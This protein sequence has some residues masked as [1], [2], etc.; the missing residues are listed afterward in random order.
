MK[1]K[2]KFRIFVI[3]VVIGFLAGDIFPLGE[4]NFYD[5]MKKNAVFVDKGAEK[6]FDELIAKS[7][8]LQSK[9]GNED[10]YP[11]QAVEMVAEDMA[12][13]LKPYSKAKKGINY[14]HDV[15]SNWKDLAKSNIRYGIDLA[16]GVEFL[17]YISEDK[18]ITSKKTSDIDVEG[19]FDRYRDI[20]I[21][22]LRNRLE[23]KGIFETE[24]SPSG[25]RYISLKAPIVSKDEKDELQR[26]IQM[27]AKLT[28]RLVHKN[29]A[30][31]IAKR[32]VNPK[33]CPVGYE[34]M[35]YVDQRPG[36]APVVRE[37][38]VKKRPEMGG[39]DI[40]K[41]HVARDRMGNLIISLSFNSKG[42]KRFGEVTAANVGRQLAIVLDGKLY[43][44][45]NIQNAI[46]GGNAQ[47]TGSFS[48]EEARNIA[49]ALEGGSLPVKMEIVAKFDIDP[50]LGRETGQS[51]INAGL[52][53]L[54]LVMIFMIAYYRKAGV[55][56][57]VAL[58]VNIILVLGALSAFGATLTLPG[59]AGIILTIGMAVDANVLIFERIREELDVGKSL[60]TA[61]HNGYDRAF[62]T[63]FDS[64]LTT[65]FTAV[66]LMNF[67]SGA[68]KGFAVTLSIGIITSMFTSLY[69]TRLIFDVWLKSK[70]FT[71]MNMMSIVKNPNVDFLAARKFTA[72]L[73]G[74][75]I[76]MTIGVF[77]FR[78]NNFGI[79]FTG[80]T[81]ITYSYDKEIKNTDIEATL[82]KANFA[83]KA[84]YKTSLIPTESG[85]NKKLEIVIRDK[86]INDANK[87]GKGKVQ[88]SPKEVISDILNKAYPN[89]HFRG[90]QEMT[91]GA[92]VGWEFAKSAMLAMFLAVLGIIAY[93]SV[94]FEFTYAVASIVALLHDVIIA[95]GIFLIFGGEMTLPVIAALLTIIGYSLNDTIVVFDRIRE[96]LDLNQEKDDEQC[97]KYERIVNMSINQTLSR[98]LLTSFT[99]LLVL[100]VLVVIGGTAVSD[101]VWVMLLGIFV[102]TY[103]SIFVASPIVTIWHKLNVEKQRRRKQEGETA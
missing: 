58:L 89:A 86:S 85:D 10:L 11:A 47:I 16:G 5:I 22:I 93:I 65:L 88:K 96:D 9:K 31:E 38:F 42:A 50:T 78:S 45:P 30:A 6:K 67:G 37:F 53:A 28:F 32:H 34:Y 64:N 98:T 43:S 14:N 1:T 59:I 92:L 13:D 90:G 99:T 56:A 70:S 55:V 15:I 94:R 51:G 74:S 25:D 41:A 80:G 68:I 102:G 66:I 40:N 83:A 33:Y 24:I 44:A 27:S 76:I 97:S 60:A 49:R 79:D 8:E 62:T 54:A 81:Q 29:N 21:E 12:I 75:L 18:D 61:I 100:I 17:L 2:V 3:L 57:C 95:T 101:F 35:T 77:L 87:K 69:M 20:A 36:K 91:M 23:E 82:A 48:F 26:L 73:S 84:S 4:K 46:R 103:S 72:I 63:I 7:K 19:N 39:K 52:V 71:T